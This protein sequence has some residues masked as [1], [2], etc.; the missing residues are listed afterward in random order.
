MAF[1]NRQ[2]TLTLNRFIDAFGP[3]PNSG[4]GDGG[5]GYLRLGM[6]RTLAAPEYYVRTPDTDG[7][8][9]S[10]SSNWPLY[11]TLGNQFGGTDFFSFALPN[12]ED[13]VAV[14]R[15][16]VLAVRY[17]QN[18]TSVEGSALPAELG[19]FATGVDNH[20]ASQELTFLVNGAGDPP[21]SAGP[22]TIGFLGQVV[23]FGGAYAPQGWFEANGQLLSI[24]DHQ[25]LYAVLGTTYGGDGVTTFALPDLVGRVAVGASNDLAVGDTFGSATTILEPALVPK[26]LGGDGEAF[27][28]RQPS[29]ALNAIVALD[30]ELP[31]FDEVPS[32]SEPVLGEVVWFAG[33]DVPGGYAKADGALLSI[34]EHPQLYALIGSV[35]GGDGVDTFALPDLRGRAIVDAGDDPIGTVR[36]SVEATLELEDFVGLE[37]RSLLVTTTDDTMDALDGKTSLREALAFANLVEDADG[38]GEAGDLI[39]F[40]PSLK[41]ATIALSQTL[42]IT[43]DVTLFGDVDGDRRA[44]IT[45]SGGGA[46]R[47]LEVSGVATDAVLQSLTLTDGLGTDGGAISATSAGSLTIL[48]TTLAHN[49]ASGR[50]G[51][52]YAHDVGDVTIV[53]SLLA[54]NRAAGDGGGAFVEGGRTTIV[55]TTFDANLATGAGAKGGGLALGGTDALLVN[56]TLTDNRAAT[57]SGAD[58]GA[59]E[60][61]N[62]VFAGNI[63]T[64]GGAAVSLSAADASSHNLVTSGDAGLGPLA[65]NGGAVDTRLPGPASPLQDAGDAS[66]LPEGITNAPNGP[67]RIAHEAVE[68]GA[69]EVPNVPPIAAPDAF[70]TDED[71]AITGNLFADNGASADSDADLDPIAIVA[72]DG[73]AAVGTEV[74]LAS[75]ARLTVGSDGTFA[76]DPS[77]AFDHLAAGAS[78]TETFSYTLSDGLNEASARVTV[79]VVGVDGPL[80]IVASPQRLAAIED[81]TGTLALEAIALADVDGSDAILVLSVEHGTI[82]PITSLFA[83]VAV[84]QI[85]PNAI[86]VSGTLAALEAYFDTHPI[87]YRGVPDAEGSG[88]DTLTIS[89][90]SASGAS[91][92]PVLASIPIDILGVNDAPILTL[93]SDLSVEEDSGAHEVEGFA[94]VLPGPA[95]ESAQ[96]V[97]LAIAA[98]SNEGL[99]AS[100]P[101]IDAT[102]RL[103]YTLAP[104]ASGSA[105]ITLVATDDGGILD[106]GANQA[107]ATFRIDVAAVNDAPTIANLAL[108]VAT[109][110]WGRGP[111]AL[112][113][114]GD[115]LVMD[116]DGED[117]SGGALIVTIEAAT[118]ADQLFLAGTPRVSVVGNLVRVDGAFVATLFGGIDGTALQIAFNGAVGASQASALLSALRYESTSAGDPS[119]SARAVAISLFD[120]DGASANVTTSIAHRASDAALTAI[121]DAYVLFEDDGPLAGNVILGSRGDGYGAGA[122]ISPT[123][124]PLQVIGVRGKAADV[125]RTI[126]LPSGLSVRIEADGAITLDPGGRF[127]DLDDGEEVVTTIDYTITDGQALTPE[128]FPAAI[129]IAAIEGAGFALQGLASRDL[130]GSAVALGDI[131]GD[132]VA[133]LMVSASNAR[134]AEGPGAGHTYV[135]FGSLG[136]GA[137]PVDLASLDG[138]NGFLIEASRQGGSARAATIVDDVNGD[139]IADIAIGHEFADLNGRD[140]GAVYIIYGSREGYDASLDAT[141]LDGS[142]G[143]VIVGDAGDGIGARV[144]SAGDVDGDGRDDLL[145]AGSDDGDGV[146]YLVLGEQARGPSVFTS[147]LDGSNGFK[148]TSPTGSEL[149]LGSALSGGGDLDG[150]GLDDM[151]VGAAGTGPNRTGAAYVLYGRAE[152]FASSLSVSGIAPSDGIRLQGSAAGDAL[153]TAVAMIGDVNAD[154]LDDFAL[155]APGSADP[156]GRAKAYVVFGVDGGFATPIDLEALDGTDGFALLG[157][158]HDELGSALAGGGD[159]NGDGI[160]DLVIGAAEG[161]GGTGA[162]RRSNAIVVFGSADG[163]GATLD[164]AALDGTDGFSLNGTGHDG[165]GSDVAIGGDFDGDGVADL[166]VGAP[167]S[168]ANGTES[169]AAFL[170]YGRSS[171]PA[172]QA[173]ASVTVT[174]RGANDAPVAVADLATGYSHAQILLSLT[175]NDIDVD[176]E[177]LT[178]ASV[179]GADEAVDQTIVLQSGALLL[180]GADGT[181]RYDPNGAFRHLADGESATDG[182]AYVA[183]DGTARSGEAQVTLT[184]EGRNDAPDARADRLTTDTSTAVSGNVLADNGSGADLDPEGGALSVVAMNGTQAAV[185]STFTLVSG[186]LLRL[187]SDGTFAYD[188][189]GAF[190]KVPIGSI[191]IDTFDY[192]VSDGTKSSSAT[193]TL[194]IEST[195]TSAAFQV[196]AAGGTGALRGAFGRFADADAVAAAGDAILVHGDAAIGPI[197]RVAVTTDDLTLQADAPFTALLELHNDGRLTLLGTAAMDV[198]GTSGADAVNGSAGANAIDGAAGDDTLRGERGDDTLTGGSGDDV[199]AGGPGAD[200]H[201]GGDGRDIA[202]FVDAP[203]SVSLNLRDPAA[204][205]GD[206]AGDSFVSV[207]AFRL[208]EH[209]DTLFGGA[210]DEAAYGGGGNDRLH[211]GEGIDTL[212]G[213]AGDDTLFGEGDRDLLKG[214]DGDDVLKGGAGTDLIYGG[215]GRDTASYDNDAAVVVDRLRPAAGTGE[216]AG[217]RYYEVEIFRLTKHGDG[218][219]GDDE[220][221]TVFGLDGGDL[222][223]GGAAGDIFVGGAGAD[224]L[225]GRGGGDVLR[226]EDGDD[227]LDGGAGAD[228]IEGGAGRDTALFDGAASAV[229][230]HLRDASRAEGE[231]A[232]DRYESIEVFQLTRFDDAFYADNT[233]VTVFGEDGDDRLIGGAGRNALSGGLGSDTILGGGGSDVLIGGAGDDLLQGGA[234]ADVHNGGGGRDAA[235]FASAGAAVG[236]DLLDPSRG[237]GEGAGDT[238]LNVEVFRLSAYDDVFVG[239]VQG[240]SVIAGDGRDTLTSGRGDDLFFGG[241][242]NDLFVIGRG[243]GRD[244]VGDFADGDR[245]G[246]ASSLGLGGFADLLITEVGSTSRIAVD[247]NRDGRADTDDLLILSNTS[248]ETLSASDFLFG[249]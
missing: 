192:T 137:T 115:A 204:G 228:R 94:S 3:F 225:T 54:G 41:G 187:E 218:F 85:G 232:G 149:G 11:S 134:F 83:G 14:G 72:V 31:Q 206:A 116:A 201:H 7:D 152:G 78:A 243:F 79:T 160:A 208:G 111:V 142:D 166:L 131:N 122:D 221:A 51:A 106:G 67:R 188:P 56:A 124:A 49:E 105:T 38:D 71:S 58:L 113:V 1:D 15:A 65:D 133:D 23:P 190:A 240:A 216:A 5:D 159:L 110:V 176:G 222:L 224:V 229:T 169:G 109:F 175:Q 154:G 80:T 81:R 102:G 184:I 21:P 164:L 75:G 34:A 8:L 98:N 247:A 63:V 194:A 199:L 245:V 129:D 28:H 29:M 112:D 234:G 69:A 44:D 91:S 213:E 88:A 191:A 76:Y 84:E 16:G 139:G 73:A 214:G 212:L 246:I 207:E 19:G 130:L 37:P 248:A 114:G 193:V 36:G 148:L 163:F 70:L 155:S 183:S 197:G 135:V 239:E 180:V 55:G 42:L 165:L 24:A 146:V 62:S 174:V 108:D 217:D 145:I 157:R 226:G 52:L 26:I 22:A 153:G 151:I 179:N 103:T 104:D 95:S 18:D 2:P 236:I 117:L 181:A 50:G 4:D 132:G 12:L 158:A 86:S 144:A 61:Y 167:S 126:E 47:L 186:A 168:A 161:T 87:A 121:D 123:G 178:V 205:K 101:T 125:G 219:I 127:E 39:S 227:V 195:P 138:T 223:V 220:G 210:A 200:V 6:I 64:D 10:A 215:E 57:H 27:D 35:F 13:A 45:L 74:V 96:T 9:L 59:A 233:N 43:S 33:T 141:A 68:I 237:F 170:I 136:R 202:V 66:R 147:A 20:Q 241:E 90:G 173:S 92:G 244:V 242:G 118:A 40:D 89:E 143:F 32:E 48:D 53:N 172:M 185:G 238:F 99:F 128:P 196:F 93:G 30:G 235:H 211:G 230:V 209:A 107:T 171:P 77:T 198:L 100:A 231:A 182:F 119:A 82:T 120:G 162:D 189:N 177:T 46:V 140:S 25:E 156:T 150:D 97:A 60:V 203:A 249:L 17:S